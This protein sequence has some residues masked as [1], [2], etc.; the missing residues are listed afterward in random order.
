M[1]TIVKLAQAF[2]DTTL[3][4]LYRDPILNAGSKFLFDFLSAYSNPNA[5]GAVADG[6]VFKN[7]VDGGADAVLAAGGGGNTVTQLAGRAGLSFTAAGGNGRYIDIGAGYDFF[8]SQHSFLVCFWD[9]QPSS[10][11]N[12]AVSYNTILTRTDNNANT[13]EFWLDMGTDGKTPRGAVGSGSN[14]PVASGA[15]GQGQGAVRQV[16]L[17]WSAGTGSFFINGSVVAMNSNFPTTLLDK[18]TSHIK[19]FGGHVATMYRVWAEDLTVSG[20]SAA[21]QVALDWAKNAARF[22]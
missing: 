11:Y 3:P 9:K 14:S 5:D 20:K 16:A 15:S 4:K 2:T 6:A 13:S 17:A 18:S 7:L 21:S 1:T 10:G 8:A 19:L 12:S 22:V